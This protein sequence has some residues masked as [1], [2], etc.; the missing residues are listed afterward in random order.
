M[1]LVGPLTLLACGPFVEKKVAHR[2][3]HIKEKKSNGYIPS[4]GRLPIHAVGDRDCHI[5]CCSVKYGTTR[6]N[7]PI[8]IIIT[9]FFL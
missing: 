3:T 6:R 8:V 5:F 2:Q 4:I 7:K 1:W 9:F